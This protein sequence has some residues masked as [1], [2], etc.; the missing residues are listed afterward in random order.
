MTTKKNNGS[1]FV[2]FLGSKDLFFLQ[3]YDLPILCICFCIIALLC[4]QKQML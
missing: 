4:A 3:K 1:I 2:F